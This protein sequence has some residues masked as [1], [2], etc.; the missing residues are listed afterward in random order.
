MLT[1]FIFKEVVF[2]LKHFQYYLFQR[3]LTYFIFKPWAFKVKGKINGKNSVH[4]RISPIYYF[5][6]FGR[7]K[8]A[9]PERPA[10]CWGQSNQAKTEVPWLTELPLL[11]APSYLK[12]KWK[13]QNPRTPPLPLPSTPSFAIFCTR[14]KEGWQTIQGLF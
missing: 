8:I 1:I 5:P 10:Q 11:Y 3:Y 2:L 6:P 12:A 4:L 13:R 7:S 14:K 9:P